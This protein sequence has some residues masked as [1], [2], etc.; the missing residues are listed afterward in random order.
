MNAIAKRPTI[1]TAKAAWGS[2]MPDWVEAL[3]RACDASSQGKVAIRLGKSG[4]M[5]SQVINRR[6]AANYTA[7][8]NL[9][10]GRLMLETVP[11][12]VIGDIALDQCHH[13]Q[14]H[15]TSAIERRIFGGACPTCP[16]RKGA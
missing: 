15:H 4:P 13:N 6:Y 2:D 14:R 1:E 11:C 7:I 3:A 5:I 10:R 8:E 12:P 16:N 9:V